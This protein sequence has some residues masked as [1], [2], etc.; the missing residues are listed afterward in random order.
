MKKI[1]RNPKWAAARYEY[2]IIGSPHVP[3]EQLKWIKAHPVR[4][5]ELD[6]DGFIIPIPEFIEVEITEQKT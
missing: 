6:A 1:V 3:A 2:V 5:D 4:G